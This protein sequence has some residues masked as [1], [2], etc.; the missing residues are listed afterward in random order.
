MLI[1]KLEVTNVAG[2]TLELPLEDDTQGFIIKNIEGLGPG[3]A[4]MAT[5]GYAALDGAQYHTSFFEPRNILITLGLVPNFEVNSTFELRSILY[6]YFMPKSEITL[7][8]TLLDKF[9]GM[10]TGQDR[11]YRQI[12]GVVESF[13]PDIFAKDPSVV[14]SVMCY[15]PDFIDPNM[16]TLSWNTV[17]DTSLT[18]FQYEGTVPTGFTFTLFVHTQID[19]VRIRHKHAISPQTRS[20][21]FSNPSETPVLTLYPDDELRVQTIPGRKYARRV[22][23]GVGEYWDAVY[24]LAYY[25]VWHQFHP[26]TNELGVLV[27]S[28]PQPYT[29]EYY[30][31][32]GGL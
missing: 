1:E 7:D 11:K 21:D 19:R 16:N 10:G 2:S 18:S 28:T 30:D 8:F 32:F 27:D 9:S 31:R 4:T 6:G 5:S 26:G 15:E 13:E 29:V 25:S 12:K 23:V 14:L 17:N 3:K 22:R 24:A 20:L